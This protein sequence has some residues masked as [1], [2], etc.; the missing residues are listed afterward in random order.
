MLMIISRE[1]R[2]IICLSTQSILWT[3]CAVTCF[4]LFLVCV[5]WFLFLIKYQGHIYINFIQSIN[6]QST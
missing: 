6:K 3:L 2:K 5:W 1:Y 4:L